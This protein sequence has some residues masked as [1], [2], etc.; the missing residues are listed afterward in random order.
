MPFL[1]AYLMKASETLAM[2]LALVALLGCVQMQLLRAVVGDRI[3][4]GCWW[5]EEVG[6]T[7]LKVC[8]ACGRGGTAVA[9][10]D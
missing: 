9:F 10:H 1:R 4:Q 8:L 3:L 2:V 6:S 5:A 7:W